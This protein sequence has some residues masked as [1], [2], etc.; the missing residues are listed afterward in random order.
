MA[1]VR[2]RRRPKEWRFIPSST[3]AIAGAATQ[4]NS[5]LAISESGA[6]IMRMLG[7]YVLAP[8]V[9]GAPVAGDRETVTV[10]IG[11]VSTDAVAVG[12]SALP[13]PAGEPEYPW[14]YWRAHSFIYPTTSLDPSGAAGSAR[15][16]FDIRSMRKLSNRTSLVFVIQVSGGNGDPDMIMIQ[17]QV[18]VLVAGA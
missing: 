13:D 15:V 10:G 14:L 11:I 8:S 7:G 6:T 9:V 18:R 1:H 3:F 2:T 17:D 5:S 12:A 16:E 4:A